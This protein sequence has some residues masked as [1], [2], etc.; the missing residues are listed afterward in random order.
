ME[1][2]VGITENY[3][4]QDWL[5]NLWGPGQ[6]E[7]AVSLFKNHQEFQDS[8]SRALNYVQGSLM[9]ESLRYDILYTP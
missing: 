1:T 5:H 7:N 4:K 6:N 9:C 2:K 3:D 8:D